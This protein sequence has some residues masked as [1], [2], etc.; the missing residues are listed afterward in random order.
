[1]ITQS[2]PGTIQ[3]ANVLS[4]AIGAESAAYA[5]MGQ[6]LNTYSNNMSVYAHDQYVEGQKMLDVQQVLKVVQ[7]VT[8]GLAILTVCGGVLFGV[9]TVGA[10]TG[11]AAAA[12]SAVDGIGKA[13]QGV[14]GAVQGGMQAYKSD[15][16][17][18][19][20]MDSTAVSSMGKASENN[21]NTIKNESQGAGKVGSAINT[22]L[23]HE[24]AI[25]RQK[26]TK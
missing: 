16:Q 17:A 7:W 19:T 23:L 6:A 24:G 20:E 14:A 22:M 9:L 12:S 1:M 26:I 25:E 5:K 4:A 10:N 13:M 8:A 2:C 3:L 18:K 21:S 15:L 11:I